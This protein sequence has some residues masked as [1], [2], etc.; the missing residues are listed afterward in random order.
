VQT[1]LDEHDAGRA[2]AVA[3]DLYERLDPESVVVTLGR[4]GAL[5]YTSAGPFWVQ[6]NEVPVRHT[7]GAGAAF[8]GGLAHACLTGATARQAVEAGCIAGTAHC[9]AISPIPHQRAHA[10][11]ISEAQP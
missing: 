11:L 3:A 7:H 4:L 5:G 9:A 1:N 2:Q 6:A 8:S 10:D